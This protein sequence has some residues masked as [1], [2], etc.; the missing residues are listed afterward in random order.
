MNNN[1]KANKLN[2][3]KQPKLKVIYRKNNKAIN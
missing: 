2:Y 1:N 3:I